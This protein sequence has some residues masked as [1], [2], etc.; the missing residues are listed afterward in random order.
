MM[1]MQ[2]DVVLLVV[3][4]SVFELKLAEEIIILYVLWHGADLTIVNLVNVI[5]D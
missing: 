3:S 2:S 5:T 4:H 1:V